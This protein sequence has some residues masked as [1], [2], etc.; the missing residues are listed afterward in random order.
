ME[1]LEIIANCKGDGKTAI[2]SC[3]DIA[4]AYKN[5]IILHFQSG[6]S[7]RVSPNSEEIDLISIMTL[8]NKVDMLNEKLEELNKKN[9]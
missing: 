7:I 8:Q 9:N 3:I 2:R 1:H 5:P 6:R 4:K